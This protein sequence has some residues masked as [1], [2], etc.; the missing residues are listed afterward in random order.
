[1]AEWWQTDEKVVKIPNIFEYIWINAN[2]AKEYSR[3]LGKLSGTSEEGPNEVSNRYI[4]VHRRLIMAKW[5]QKAEKGG[6]SFQY[7]GSKKLQANRPKGSFQRS[8]VWRKQMGPH[9]THAVSKRYI[10]SRR[11]LE[12]PL[13]LYGAGASR[14]LMGYTRW[15]SRRSGML[16]SALGRGFPPNP[17][18]FR[19]GSTC[20]DPNTHL[21]QK[22]RP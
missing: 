19:A 14:P 3:G 22:S 16:S 1:M 7:I 17:P 21:T 2:R 12:A 15:R 11:C 9:Q 20:A 8:G 13:R 5:R 18:I 4:L 6:K 10:L